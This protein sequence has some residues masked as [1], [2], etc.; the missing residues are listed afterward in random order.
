MD[1]INKAK[2][3][4]TE[5]GVKSSITFQN[6]SVTPFKKRKKKCVFGYVVR[7]EVKNGLD[8]KRDI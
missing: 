8:S 6:L 1:K 5:R 4:P 2:Y 3:A 7:E